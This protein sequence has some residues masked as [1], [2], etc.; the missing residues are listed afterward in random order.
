MLNRQAGATA[1]EFL[2]ERQSRAQRRLDH[3]RTGSLDD[4]IQKN[5]EMGFLTSP[6]LQFSNELLVLSEGTY[7]S[8]EELAA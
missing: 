3:D 8:M 2:Y 7:S 1:F 5:P 4:S 6:Y